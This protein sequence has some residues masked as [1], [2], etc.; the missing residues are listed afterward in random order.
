MNPF[1]DNF[2]GVG[3]EL[4]MREEL[5][6]VVK[7][8]RGGPAEQAGLEADDRLVAIDHSP[9]RG[10]ALADVVVRLRGREGSKVGVTVQRGKVAIDTELVR[11]S[12]ERTQTGYTARE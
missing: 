3:V 7:T 11:H 4:T 9:I 8:L 1:P 6:I 12:M 5:P 2:V 10:L